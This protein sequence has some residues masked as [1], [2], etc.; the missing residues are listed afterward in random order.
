MRF[1]AGQPGIVVRP[2]A[3]VARAT[4][5]DSGRRRRPCR[6]SAA[7]SFRGRLRA[8]RRTPGRRRRPAPAGAHV[9]RCCAACALPP[10]FFAT[11]RVGDC[12][13]AGRPRGGHAGTRNG[14][15]E[16]AVHDKAPGH[17]VAGRLTGPDVERKAPGTGPCIIIYAIA[18]GQKRCACGQA[19]CARAQRLHAPWLPR[20]HRARG[21]AR[22]G[23]DGAPRPG[24][25][26][27]PRGDARAPDAS[28]L[29]C[30]RTPVSRSTVV[31]LK[32]TRSRL[33]TPGR[34]R[35]QP[36]AP[37]LLETIPSRPNNR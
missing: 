14:C 8:V 36:V 34:P 1:S 16:P 29:P 35:R 15:R 4:A 32:E 23:Y 13:A 18:N 7:C 27:T 19:R 26:S 10:V 30:L 2:P 17:Q 33:T 20:A 5:S 21:D 31:S 22:P 11:R 37:P 24:D 9:R 25:A 12:P 3:R 6:M 28:G